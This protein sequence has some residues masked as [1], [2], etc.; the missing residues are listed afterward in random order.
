[1]NQR[2]GLHRLRI[3]CMILIMVSLLGACLMTGCGKEEATQLVDTKEEV[4]GETATETADESV[5]VKQPVEETV[6]EESME[7]II[8]EEEAEDDTANLSNEEWVLSLNVERPTFLVFNEIIGERKALED[9][10]EYTLV[11]G[12]ELA[13]EIPSRWLWQ[14]DNIGIYSTKENKYN[15]VVY[16][17]NYDMISEK[18]EF[19]TTYNNRDGQPVTVTVYLSK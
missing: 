16:T 9:G 1:M 11:D 2:N 7:E 6:A 17:L 12:D 18:T 5:E 8:V 10:A 3:S 19:A 15:C 13:I 14:G 4:V